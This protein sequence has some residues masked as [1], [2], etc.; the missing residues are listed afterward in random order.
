MLQTKVE[1]K[2]DINKTKTEQKNNIKRRIRS[3]GKP[4]KTSMF[5]IF[6][7]LLINMLFNFI[8]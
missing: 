2:Q 3:H 5:D 7:M 6:C 4:I 8:Y 1:Q